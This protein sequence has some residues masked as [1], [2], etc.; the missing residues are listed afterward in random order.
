MLEVYNAY[1]LV[2]CKISRKNSLYLK[3]HCAETPKA[4]IDPHSSNTRNIHEIR[5]P[6]IVADV[7]N[8]ISMV[9]YT[10]SATRRDPRAILRH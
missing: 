3:V 9:R 8:A 6:V 5:L 10:C 1:T 2:Q 7:E 4:T